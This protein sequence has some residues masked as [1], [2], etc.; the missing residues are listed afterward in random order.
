VVE[1]FRAISVP[2]I[3]VVFLNDVES[4]VVEMSS[5]RM[6]RGVSKDYRVVTLSTG[7]GIGWAAIGIKYGLTR[8]A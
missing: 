8:G 5:R 6:R 7:E 3:V 4:N 2:E 1:W